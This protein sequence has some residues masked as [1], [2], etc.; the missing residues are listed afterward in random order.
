[1]F[2]TSLHSSGSAHD[3]MASGIAMFGI[4]LVVYATHELRRRRPH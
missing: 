1:M 3:F 4:F 2:P